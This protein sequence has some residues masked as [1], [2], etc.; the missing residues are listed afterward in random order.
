MADIVITEFMDEES[1][2]ALAAD[3]NVV[4]DPGLVDGP[5]KIRNLVSDARGLIVRN[6]TRVDA[7]LLDAAPLLRVVGR[8]GVG[9]D[10]IDLDTCS[11]RGIAVCP[12]TGA[13][14]IAVAEYVIC[15]AML[16]LRTAFMNSGAVQKGEWPRQRSMG[17]EVFGKRLGLIGCGG[18]A[19][20]TAQRGLALGMS[21]AAYDPLI[22]SENNVW[23]T[24]HRCT[25]VDDLLAQAD[26]VSLHVP[27]TPDTRNLVDQRFIRG[28]KQGAVLVNTSRGG[29]VDEIALVDA[30]RSGALGGAA[31]DVFAEEPLSVVAGARF[32][33]LPN[34]LLTPHIGGVTTESNGR[35]SQVTADNVRKYL[36]T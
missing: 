32:E 13:N 22:S 20:Q 6:R 21:I 31:L 17:S 36:Q 4:Y 29:V 28:M 18:I 33:D 1:V 27:L 30:L 7:G 2:D 8:L 24:I 10:N 34:L 9:L 25:K 19:R 5:D 23:A 15:A 14:D 26:I 35:V 11:A 12:A 16:L 3:Y